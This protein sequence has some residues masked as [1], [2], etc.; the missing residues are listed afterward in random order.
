MTPTRK[1]NDDSPVQYPNEI[2]KPQCWEKTNGS[3]RHHNNC[4]SNRSGKHER[5]RK[6]KQIATAGADTAAGSKFSPKCDTAHVR[7]LHPSDYATFSSPEPT[8]LLACGRDRELWVGLTPEVH[9]SRTS[10]QI[11]LVENTKRMLCAYSE[12]RVR[13]ELSIP[14]TGQK[15]RGLWGR[16]WLRESG[17]FGFVSLFSGPFQR[18]SRHFKNSV[19]YY[20]L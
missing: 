2:M 18:T 12:N 5:A 15:D 17:C 13:P 7:R 8:I 10:H 3:F 9:D 4:G 16:E 11:W 6:F 19:G 1:N 14:T 20:I